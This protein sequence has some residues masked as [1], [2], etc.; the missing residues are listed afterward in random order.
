MRNQIDNVKN[1]LAK[2]KSEWDREKKK[3]I[4]EH[5]VTIEQV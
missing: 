3:L 4:A 2:Q 5:E 1:D